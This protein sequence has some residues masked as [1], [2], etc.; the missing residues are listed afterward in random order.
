[1]MLHLQD[2]GMLPGGFGW[3]A[4]WKRVCL[5]QVV[6]IHLSPVSIPYIC[7]VLRKNLVNSTS[8]RY[9]C[10]RMTTSQNWAFTS[11]EKIA[12]APDQWQLDE[13]GYRLLEKTSWVV[14]EKIHGANFCFIS[15]GQS[16]V[17]ANRK[18][19]LADNEDFFHYQVLLERRR[20]T[21]ERVFFLTRARYPHLERVF[22]YGELFGGTY[23]HPNVR[24]DSAVQPVQ[25]GIYYAPTIEFCAFDIAIEC[26]SSEPAHNY[27]DYDQAITIFKEAGLLYAIPLFIGSYGEAL[28]YPVGFASTI[29]ALLGLPPLAAENKAEGIVIKPQKTLYIATNKGSIRP[30]L[31]KKI[32]EFAEDKRFAQAQKWSPSH[33][34]YTQNALE[35]LKW[36]V[37]NLMTQNRL[38]SAISK[39]GAISRREKRKTSRVFNVLV[40]DVLDQLA[41]NQGTLLTTLS[42]HERAEL[43][44]YIQTE[45]RTLLK[46]YFRS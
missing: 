5:R 30:I 37:F 1:M 25:T 32:P 18:A 10:Y 38:H 43:I 11:Y 8:I 40:E 22:V 24:P 36:E 20:T 16:I 7:N 6:A 4:T 44:T 46:A 12:E 17:C 28:A 23:P 2:P 29:P 19:I 33:T 26:A 14:T 34:E 15:D 45:A 42:E 13:A 35:Q 3:K 21:I 9:D 39:V 27:L 41:I 31:K